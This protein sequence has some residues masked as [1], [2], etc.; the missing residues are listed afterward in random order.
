[1]TN[2]RM[3][4]YHREA[5]KKNLYQFDAKQIFGWWNVDMNWWKSTRRWSISYKRNLACIVNM[6]KLQV[7][8]WFN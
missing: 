1:M 8:V 6:G 3:K 5:V 4:E 7:I 2:N